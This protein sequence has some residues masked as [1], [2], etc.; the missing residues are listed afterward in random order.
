MAYEYRA[1][2]VKVIDGD[3][4][5]LLVDCGFHDYRLER[6][7]LFGINTA[8]MRAADLTARDQAMKAKEQM[9][10]WLLPF[11]VPPSV[12]GPWSVRIK[13]YKADAFGRYLCDLW[14]RVEGT[15]LLLNEE[16]IKLGLAVPFKR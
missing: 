7:R 4:V 16:L 5:D 9:V 3:T 14:A 2:C 15:E 10:K 8:E 13:T 6:F 12:D 1:Q 11:A